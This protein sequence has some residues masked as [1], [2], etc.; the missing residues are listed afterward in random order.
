MERD[1]DAMEFSESN[2]VEILIHDEILKE[3][4]KLGRQLISHSIQMRQIRPSDLTPNMVFNDGIDQSGD[5]T[6]APRFLRSIVQEWHGSE[7][8]YEDIVFLCQFVISRPIV[9]TGTSAMSNRF[10]FKLG[11]YQSTVCFK[12]CALRF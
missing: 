12:V 2:D 1:G 3:E 7:H 11:N 10:C 9:T 5:L 6:N 8:L 4:L